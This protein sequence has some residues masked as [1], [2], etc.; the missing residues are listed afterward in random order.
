MHR[1]TSRR[2]DARLIASIFFGPRRSAFAG[3]RPAAGAMLASVQPP[4]RS[5][6]QRQHAADGDFP[7][8]QLIDHMTLVPH[9]PQVARRALDDDADGLPASRKR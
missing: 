3:L 1:R 5:R 9:G 2:H 4:T 6:S 8:V 7:A